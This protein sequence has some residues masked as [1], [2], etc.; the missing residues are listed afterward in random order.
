MP[1]LSEGAGEDSMRHKAGRMGPLRTI[2]FSDLKKVLIKIVEIHARLQLE[3]LL[4]RE[5]KSRSLTD[6]NKA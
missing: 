2:G 1:A 6:K 4:P 5:E 3:F